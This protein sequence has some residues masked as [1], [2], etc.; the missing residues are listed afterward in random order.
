MRLRPTNLLDLPVY[1]PDRDGACGSEFIQEAYLKERETLQ[2]STQLRPFVKRW[3]ALFLLRFGPRM[4]GQDEAPSQANRD[5]L[6]LVE[7]R[8]D[9]KRVINV[10][11]NAKTIPFNNDDH[12]HRIAA[13]ILIPPA[14]Y[15]AFEIREHF[16]VGHDLGMVRLYLDSW[17]QLDH[18]LGH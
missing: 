6:A 10:I 4:R 3:R 9:A 14:L 18:T 12:N 16:G 17:P 2:R 1:P 5:M 7:G 15:R 8:F 11:V 13:N